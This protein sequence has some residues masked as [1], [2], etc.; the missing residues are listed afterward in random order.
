MTYSMMKLLLTMALMVQAAVSF[1]FPKFNIPKHTFNSEQL[2]KVSQKGVLIGSTFI[3]VCLL[4]IN[5]VQ[6]AF[7]DLASDDRYYFLRC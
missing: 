4:N 6:P 2:A 5:G 7:A 1:S 3:A